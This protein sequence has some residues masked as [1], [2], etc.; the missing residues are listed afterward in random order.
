[1]GNILKRA[2]DISY[3]ENRKIES[4]EERKHLTNVELVVL[5]DPSLFRCGTVN[6]TSVR[7]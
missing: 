7:E 1:M 3:T 5:E 6:S 4:M 2:E